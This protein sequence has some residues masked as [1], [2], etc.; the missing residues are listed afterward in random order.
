MASLKVVFGLL[1]AASLLAAPV[2]AQ[3]LSSQYARVTLV[4]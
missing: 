1:A 2:A 3:D 4:T